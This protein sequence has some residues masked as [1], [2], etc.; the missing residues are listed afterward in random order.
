MRKSLAA[1]ALVLA[2]GCGKRG[3]P[4]PPVPVIPKATSDLVVAQRGANLILSWSFP[5]LSTTG[6]K[7]GAIRRVVVYRY[8][9]PLPVT[10]P[11]RD[12][13]TLMPGDIDPT[14]PTA[15]ALFAKVPPIGRQQ[16]TRVRQRVDSLESSQLP[17]ATA[18]A[19]LVYE[20]SPDFHTSDGRPVRIDYA[21]VTEGTSAKSEMSNIAAIVPVDVPV[22]PDSLTA[23]A[24]PE[25]LVLTW[26]AP[27]KVIAGDEKPHIAG[28]NIYRLPKG[29]QIGQTA[30][31][32][33]TAPVSQTTYTD[34]P[35][36]GV[37]QYVVTAVA[38]TGPP[39]IESDPSAP[40][41]A[42][43]K[44]LVPPPTPTGLTALIEP[45]VVRIV[46]DPVQAPDLAG[47]KVYRWEGVGIEKPVVIPKRIPVSGLLTET[48]LIDSGLSPGIAYYFEVTSVDKSGNESKPAKTDW[49][50]VPKTP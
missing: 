10:E 36:Y 49:V 23:R 35:P 13:K 25:G 16:F 32:V 27:A 8:S 5:S 22:P 11:P 28:Y 39:R 26:N 30:T 4:H 38:S 33:N 40:A 14:V 12:T 24:Q 1:A 9:E 3:D 29:E 20:D 7:L 45:N 37:H 15:I 41:S 18:G 48:H 43:F 46:W 50:V 17:V 19:R 2:L 42:E 47:Y 21:V 44:D 34:A 31:P 6:A